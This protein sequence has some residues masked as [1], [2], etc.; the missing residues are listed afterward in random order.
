[1]GIDV[2]E[3]MVEMQV[4]QG[5]QTQLG[6]AGPVGGDNADSLESN[7]EE[8][9]GDDGGDDRGNDGGVDDGVAGGIC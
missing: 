5:S 4:Q 2:Y 9:D 3:F 7:S 8:D 1:M 6:G